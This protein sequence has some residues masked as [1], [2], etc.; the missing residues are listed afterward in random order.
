MKI[1]LIFS[2]VKDTGFVNTSLIFSV[3]LKFQLE[4]TENKSAFLPHLS[5]LTPQILS[6]AHHPPLV[7]LRVRT[8]CSTGLIECSLSRCPF[9]EGK[10]LTYNG[11]K[12][13]VC[14]ISVVLSLGLLV[15]SI[16]QCICPGDS[17]AL[18]LYVTPAI[19]EGRRSL[20]SRLLILQ[21]CLASFGSLF[22]HLNGQSLKN[23]LLGF[24]LELHWIHISIWRRRDIVLE[25][26]RPWRGYMSF[27]WVFTYG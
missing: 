25:I 1:S 26:L 3:N 4:V 18:W 21:K 22:F 10:S 6:P 16:D 20:L 7:D 24:G 14:I 9:I 8:P 19:W 27:T 13:S 15:C 2:N 23:N 12:S 5:F 17:I 11:H